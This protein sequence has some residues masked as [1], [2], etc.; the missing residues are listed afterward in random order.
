MHLPQHGNAKC[1]EENI[2]TSEARLR[3][4]GACGS[5]CILLI[6]VGGRN[7]VSH[8]T[9]YSRGKTL[10]LF[11]PSPLKQHSNSGVSCLAQENQIAL[12]QCFVITKC[13]DDWIGRGG[14]PFCFSPRPHVP[15]PCWREAN[16][17]VCHWLTSWDL[18]QGLQ[19]ATLTMQID[20]IKGV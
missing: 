17:R 18:D 7:N 4:W 9:C 16:G 11:L 6:I 10:L 13:K 15:L 3:F 20:I 14:L 8:N 12:L 1:P 19:H 2:A 5:N